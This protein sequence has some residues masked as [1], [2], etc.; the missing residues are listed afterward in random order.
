MATYDPETRRALARLKTEPSL[1]VVYRHIEASY[2]Q[3]ARECVAMGGDPSVAGLANSYLK[4]LED[5]DN[6]AATEQSASVDVREGF[7]RGA[8]TAGVS[9]W[10]G[11]NHYA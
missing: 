1:Q 3:Y 8:H 2:H 10:N 9:G 11:A 7:T 4:L 5:I 6:A